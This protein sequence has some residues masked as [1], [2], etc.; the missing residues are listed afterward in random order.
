MARINEFMAQLDL[1]PLYDLCQN[2]G[3][4][5]NYRKGDCLVEEGSVCRYIGMVQS[6]YFKYTV[7]RSDGEVCVTGF[8]FAHELVTDY[9]RSFL[10]NKPAM[11][12]I[13]AG[14][15]ATVLQVPIAHARPYMVEHNPAIIANVSSLL[16]QEAYSRYLSIH[17]LTPLE[18]YRELLPRFHDV[19]DQIPYCEIASYLSVSRRQFQRI[20]AA[21][22]L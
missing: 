2:Q 13:V 10:Y 9:V 7:V 18:R 1:Q 20:R 16:L 14:C 6:G 4:I 11:V 21:I 8:S 22:S 17:T 5:V 19:I 15:D 3:E 12:S